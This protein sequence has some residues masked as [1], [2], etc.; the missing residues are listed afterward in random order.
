MNNFW[1]N[2][3]NVM[4]KVIKK[5]QLIFSK[6]FTIFWNGLNVMNRRTTINIIVQNFMVKKCNFKN[7]RFLRKLFYVVLSFRDKGEKMLFSWNFEQFSILSLKFYWPEKFTIFEIIINKI[8]RN[9]WTIFKTI[10]K[11]S[12]NYKIG[13]I[14]STCIISQYK[15]FMF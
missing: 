10:G 9:L 7:I 2:V 13:N 6:S 8:V 12:L 1:N 5:L 11:I 14:I 15:Y 4:A 3:R